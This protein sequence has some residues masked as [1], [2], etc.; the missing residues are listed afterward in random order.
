[1]RKRFEAI[2]IGD[3]IVIKVLHTGRSTVKIGIQAPANVKVLR[4]ELCAPGQ[5]EML[6]ALAVSRNRKRPGE[7]VA[8]PTPST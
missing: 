4:A 2:Q 3:G 7:R 6:A 5:R 8:E 1:M